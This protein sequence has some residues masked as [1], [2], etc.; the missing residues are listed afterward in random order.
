VGDVARLEG[1]GAELAL[2]AA[3]VLLG[4]APGPGVHSGAGGAGRKLPGE[5]RTIS[6][7]FV[8]SRLRQEGISAD[9]VVLSGERRVTV[10]ARPSFCEQGIARA[11]RSHVA[12]E[13][14][15]PEEAVEVD[16][17]GFRWIERPVVAKGL[18]FAVS[19]LAG[20]SDL[21]RAK[22][23]LDC[24]DT[25]G[26][27]R[28]AGRALAWTDTVRY[29]AAVASRSP[30]ARGAT[31][32]P[33]DLV[34]VAAPVR[35]AGVALL[36]DP[37]EASGREAARAIEAGEPIDETALLARRLVRQGETVTALIETPGY[38][39][40]SRARAV[41]SGARGE[42]IPVENLGSGRE[43]LARVVGENTVVV[44]P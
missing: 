6:R 36:S 16:L 38:R 13:L 12:G 11:V 33:E 32:D 28:P 39:I 34:T 5:V 29:R 31:L 1:G 40:T 2:R 3:G 42:V 20:G 15:C 9:T 19:K 4:A 14:G 17:L 7:G 30:V 37:E 10:S 22:Y 35:E 18:T 43:F 8:A 25:A 23:V 24:L 26:G 41:R 27:G 44:I 21:G